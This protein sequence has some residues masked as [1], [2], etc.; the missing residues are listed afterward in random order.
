MAEFHPFTSVFDDD[1]AVRHPYFRD[2]AVDM[3]ESGT[4]T[5]LAAA[6]TNNRAR[7]WTHHLGHI[8]SSVIDAGLTI[9]HLH[10]LAETPERR[11][12]FLIRDAERG[13]Y[14]FPPSPPCLPLV[15]TLSARKPDRR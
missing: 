12:P 5:D 11:W 6:T 14:R 10:E 8:V 7:R 9:H 15:Y 2:T 4:Y 3:D 1:V 13:T